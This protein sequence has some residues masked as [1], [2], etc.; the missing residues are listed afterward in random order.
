MHNEKIQEPKNIAM[1]IRALVANLSVASEAN[2]KIKRH[3]WVQPRRNCV[4]LNV[5]RAFHPDLLQ[6][7]YGVV[8]RDSSGKFVVAGNGKIEWCGDALMA[9]VMALLFGLNLATTVGCNRIEVNSNSIEVIETM[10][11]V[12]GLLELRRQYL[13]IAI[14]LLVISHILF[15]S[16]FL[17]RQTVL[18]MI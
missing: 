2:A 10:K 6:G 17:G 16:I 8:I 18:P 1:V 4:K 12:D 9:E 3:G 7:S 14:I 15:F 5:D 13:M 11:N